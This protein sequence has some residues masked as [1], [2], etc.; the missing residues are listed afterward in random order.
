MATILEVDGSS[1][2]GSTATQQSSQDLDDRD[3]FLQLLITQL[4]YQDPLDPM[5]NSEFSAQLA[6]FSSLE[7]L[8]NI[9]DKLDEALQV[10]MLLAQ[11]INNTMAATLIG[12][13]IH[14]AVD[15]VQFDGESD[16]EISFDLSGVASEVD[17][18]IRNENGKLVRTLNDV[19]LAEGVHTVDWNGRDDRGNLL[20]PGSYDVEVSADMQG[21]S[22]VAV[23]PLLIGRVDGVKFVDGSP[24]LRVNGQDVSFGVVLQIMEE[25]PNRSRSWFSQMIRDGQ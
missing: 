1:Y 8:N 20:P 12:K 16:A 25:D 9:G 21:G 18:E 13:D 17:I 22:T 2:S 11:S 7:Q 19:N 24:V 23:Q 5:A 6:Q 10:D 14:A 15:S 4:Q 3:T